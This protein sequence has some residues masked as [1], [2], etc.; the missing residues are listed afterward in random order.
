MGKQERRTEA[1]IFGSEDAP[2]AQLNSRL[3]VDVI[4]SPSTTD[5]EVVGNIAHDGVDSGNPVKVGLRALAHGT[6]P[7]A[8]AAADRTDW[9]ASRAGI[10]WVIGGH[11]NV[12][13]R[14]ITVLDS[15][16]AQTNASLVGTIAAGT[17]LVVTALEVTC[18]GANTADV[19]VRIGFHASTL[20]TASLTGVNAILLSHAGIKAGSGVVKG[21][22]SGI[23]GIGA[24]GEEIR[25]TCED[26]V[27]GA[28]RVVLTYYTIES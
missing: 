8:V 16:G 25:M 13:T 4:T 5:Q 17:I 19:A 1:T 22:G 27:G 11:P 24:D 12:I 10:P 14:E 23:L 21:D 18:D 26:P 15:D 9:L 7:T 6:N 28:L 3:Q 20:P 2:A